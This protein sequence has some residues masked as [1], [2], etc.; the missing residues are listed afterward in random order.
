MKK[1]AVF[2]SSTYSDLSI[3]RKQIWL[4]VEKFG[5]ITLGME[6]FGA[7]KENSLTTCLQEVEKCDIFIL[8]VGMRF[9]SIHKPSQKSYTW[10]EYEKAYELRKDILVYLIDE[11]GG[12]IKVSDFDVENH[13]NLCDF[14]DIL[15]NN[16][17]VD[18]FI[19]TDDLTGKIFEL[20]E[21]RTNNLNSEKVRPE[22]IECDLIRFNQNNKHYIFIIGLIDGK[23]FELHSAVNEFDD[24]LMLPRN[25]TKATLIEVWEGLENK[26]I[27]IQYINKRGYKTTIEGVNFYTNEITENP[28]LDKTISSLL[29]GDVDKGTLLNVLEGLSHMSAFSKNWAEQLIELV[30]NK[31]FT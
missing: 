19:E 17:T 1:P 11:K 23:P 29:R 8:I 31:Y 6:K 2:I 27:D 12:Q 5:L 24:G 16:H 26:R 30:I 13:K 25:L 28:M 7:R 3:H 10:L 9:G 21:L 4:T 15:R 18:S 22:K 14:K 20:L